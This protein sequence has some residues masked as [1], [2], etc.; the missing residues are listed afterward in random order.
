[1][2]RHHLSVVQGGQSNAPRRKDQHL[3][4]RA[5]LDYL[6]TEIAD[7]IVQL[8]H[9]APQC[10]IGAVLGTVLRDLR[11]ALDRAAEIDLWMSV[12]EVAKLTGRPTSTITRICREHGLAAGASKHKGAWMIHWGRFEAFL[13]SPTHNKEGAA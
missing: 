2:E 4:A 3:I 7:E 8:N 10:E 5:P 1:M 12:D 13:I 11:I 9:R 6:A